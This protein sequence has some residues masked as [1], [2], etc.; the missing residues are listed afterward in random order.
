MPHRVHHKV[1]FETIEMAE[2]L[3]IAYFGNDSVCAGEL[4]QRHKQLCDVN[5]SGYNAKGIAE[6]HNERNT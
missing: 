4:L 6:I 2:L 3:T 1:H 5:N